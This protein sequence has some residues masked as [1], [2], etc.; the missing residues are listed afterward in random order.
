LI[1]LL[2]LIA[3]FRESY[4]SGK[5][6]DGIKSGFWTGMSSGAFACLSALLL[7]VFGMKL[8]LIDPLNIKEWTDTKGSFTVPGMDI[9]FA[10]QSFAGAMIHL[11]I[12]GII[13]GLLLGSLGGLTANFFKII[14]K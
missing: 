6:T 5:F 2:I 14:L 11:Y 4:K 8:I 12:L 13:M 1:A 9:Y 3:S 10:Y 7:I